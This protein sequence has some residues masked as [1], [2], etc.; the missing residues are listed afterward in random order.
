MGVDKRALVDEAS[1]DRRVLN[2][3]RR[4]LS[5]VGKRG[6]TSDVSRCVLSDVG[7]H[8]LKNIGGST[9]GKKSNDEG[10]E[11]LPSSCWMT[12]AATCAMLVPP[13]FVRL[14]LSLGV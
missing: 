5:N 11:V 10:K 13:I 14:K 9:S 7:G 8:V 6:L 4:V 3:G 1:L 12:T 2:I